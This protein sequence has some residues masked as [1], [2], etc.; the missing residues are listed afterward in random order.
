MVHTAP[1]VYKSEATKFQNIPV[2]NYV[3]VMRVH[4]DN[5]HNST[6][7]HY[8]TGSVTQSHGQTIST[9]ALYFRS[10]VINSWLGSPDSLTELF[11]GFPQYLQGNA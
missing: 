3:Y 7:A 2:T 5:E 11:C 8:L 1:H 6:S 4:A 10:P 9:P